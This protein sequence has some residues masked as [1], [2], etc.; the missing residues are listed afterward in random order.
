MTSV[1]RESSNDLHLRQ[2]AKSQH[3]TTLAAPLSIPQKQGKKYAFR[4]QLTLAHG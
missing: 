2:S 3:E 4:T 1:G